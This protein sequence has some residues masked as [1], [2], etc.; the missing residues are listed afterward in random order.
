METDLN[1]ANLGMYYGTE[2]YHKLVPFIRTV[3]TDGVKYIMDN[4][5]SWF[6]TDTLI[7]IEHSDKCLKEDFIAIKLE[8]NVEKKTAK[9]YITEGNN[10]NLIP[11]RDIEYTDAKRDLTLYLI[12][13]VLMLMSEY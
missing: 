6:V 12:N 11:I 8:V 1:L 3:V 4:G 10:L 7:E 2:Q 13:D 9:I 5:Y